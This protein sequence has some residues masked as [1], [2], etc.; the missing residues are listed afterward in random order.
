M[1]RAA[2]AHLAVVHIASMNARIE[3]RDFSSRRGHTDRPYH[4]PDGKTQSFRELAPTI[5][6][7]NNA[8]PELRRA[9][10][11]QT[12]PGFDGRESLAVQLYVFDKNQ[13]RISRFGALHLNRAGDRIESH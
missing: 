9:L 7:S 8:R 13:Q 4:G 10:S 12:N 6:D 3:R 11:Q 1:D 5:I 2:D